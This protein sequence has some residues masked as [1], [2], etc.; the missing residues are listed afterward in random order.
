MGLLIES[1]AFFLERDWIGLM[2]I[3]GSLDVRRVR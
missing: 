1:N 3:V 2:A